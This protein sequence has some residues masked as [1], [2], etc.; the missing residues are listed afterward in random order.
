[1]LCYAMLCYAMLCCEL[2]VEI[3]PNSEGMRN[4]TQQL[5]CWSPA[6]AVLRAHNRWTL[7]KHKCFS[8]S[9][10]NL[11]G[12]NR[13]SQKVMPALTPCAEISM[14]LTMS[15]W[16]DLFSTCIFLRSVQWTALQWHVNDTLAELWLTVCSFQAL[17]ASPSSQC[18][19]EHHA[20]SRSTLHPS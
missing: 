6:Q 16:W 1:M 11:Q 17:I 10:A 15:N 18:W 8:Q 3:N 9:F 2:L 20:V 5:T 14:L 19:I 4:T 7:S 13:I 12:I